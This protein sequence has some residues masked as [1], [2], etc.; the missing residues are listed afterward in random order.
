M[1]SSAAFGKIGEAYVAEIR[2]WEKQEGIS[3]HQ[4][5]KGENKELYARPLIEAAAKEGSEGRVVLLLVLPRRRPPC[6]IP[7][8]SRTTRAG[9][10]RWGGADRRP[11]VQL[12][13]GST[14]RVTT[15]VENRP[16]VLGISRRSKTSTTCWGRPTS[17]WS[18]IMPS[19]KARPAWGRSKTRVSEISNWRKA[20]S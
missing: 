7:G 12:T 17:T 15:L 20:S 11:K 18:R 8:V 2:R 9:V 3:E 10:L 6:G 14:P 4:F 5:D 13:W 19:K 16:G 1:P